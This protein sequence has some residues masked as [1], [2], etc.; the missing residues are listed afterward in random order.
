[1]RRG[2]I[3][4]VAM[5][6]LV[7]ACD[8]KSKSTS[9]TTT[10]GT[11][12]TTTA[13]TATTAAPALPTAYVDSGDYVN[14]RHI[15]VIKSVG[16][17]NHTIDIDVEQFLTGDASGTPDNDYYIV[18]QSKLV[19]HLTVADSAALRLQTLAQDAPLATSP[20]KGKSIDWPAFAQLWT[21]HANAATNTLFWIT[22]QGGVVVSVE[23][24]FVP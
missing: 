3:L 8:S 16:A 14:G 9:T 4:L 7:G 1:M 19:R 5:T 18:N 23:E 22:L 17:G 21:T 24:Q 2:V 15:G 11:T 13:D 20:D 12:T 10:T 6:L